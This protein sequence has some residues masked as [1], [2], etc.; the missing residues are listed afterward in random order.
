METILA[1]YARIVSLGI[2]L[3]FALAIRHKLAVVLNGTAEAEPLLALSA[4][5]RAH[6]AT[7][8]ALVTI[9]EAIVALLL[10]ATP[11]VGLAA[12]ALLTACYTLQLRRLPPNEPC[13]CFG[14]AFSVQSRTT[15][16]TRNFVI[17][18]LSAPLAL[19]YVTGLPIAPIAGRV[20]DTALLLCTCIVSIDGFRRLF[21]PAEA[22]D[23]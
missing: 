12:T 19:L 6:A 4:F 22:A 14:A 21:S 8:F 1:E 13:N 15:A 10:I 17:V 18:I 9:V 5:R 20:L 2:A 3:L 7:I 23:A 11:A 16:M